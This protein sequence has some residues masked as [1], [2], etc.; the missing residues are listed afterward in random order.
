[1]GFCKNKRFKWLVGEWFEAFPLQPFERG[2][3]SVKSVERNRQRCETSK[4]CTFVATAAQSA[5]DWLGGLCCPSSKV[6]ETL[7]CRE[8]RNLGRPWAEQ[9]AEW[10]PPTCNVCAGAGADSL[11]QAMHYWLRKITEKNNLNFYFSFRTELKQKILSIK[12][13]A[14]FIP[15]W[16]FLLFILLHPPKPCGM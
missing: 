3:T 5:G 8:R 12:K 14:A 16:A 4:L 10:R 11:A 2:T 15:S 7:C 6:Q 1:M 13:Q 9:G